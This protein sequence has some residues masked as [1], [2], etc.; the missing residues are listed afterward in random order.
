M[1]R[2]QSECVPIKINSNIFLESRTS[3]DSIR[4]RTDTI[5]VSIKLSEPLLQYT[6]IR[7]LFFSF[8]RNILIQV[9]RII[10]AAHLDKL[11]TTKLRCSSHIAE[12]YPAFLCEI[13]PPLLCGLFH[14]C[15]QAADSSS[16]T[17]RHLH[18]S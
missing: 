9:Y 13:C 5:K 1:R 17:L 11:E 10:L 8:S 12:V 15:E 4:V 2:N 18:P 6:K 16:E 7:N 14:R 3:I